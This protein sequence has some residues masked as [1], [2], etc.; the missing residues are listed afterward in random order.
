MTRVSKSLL[1]GLIGLAVVVTGCQ[2]NSSSPTSTPTAQ[3]DTATP[4][5]V[6]PDAQPSAPST[7]ASEPEKSDK[8]TVAQPAN[9]PDMAT[10]SIYV[11]DDSCND[12]VKESVQ[13]AE[14][15]AASD[16]VGKVIAYGSFAEFK[17]SGYRVNIDASSGVATVDLR[18]DPSSVR[19]F[20][21]L[22]SCEQRSLFGGIEET[23]MQNPDWK[24][25][26]VRFTNR[27]EALVL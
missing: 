7:S 18:L 19:T 25:K 10:V 15:Q 21:S 6:T 12:F 8:P 1:I 9:T 3:T 11:M 4:P 20:V 5:T 26:E 24:V 17:L 23:L 22:S 27:G 13:V 16:A 14:P 2:G